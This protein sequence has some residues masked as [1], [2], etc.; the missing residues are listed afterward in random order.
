MERAIKITMREKNLSH[1]YK[2]KQAIHP[3]KPMRN[4]YQLLTRH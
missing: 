3:P 2:I 1:L 4:L